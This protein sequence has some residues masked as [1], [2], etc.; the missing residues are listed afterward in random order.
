[1][2]CCACRE[3]ALRT[4]D[5]LFEQFHMEASCMIITRRVSSWGGLE[6]LYD[7][8]RCLHLTFALQYS[9]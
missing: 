2:A 6:V 1:M 8:T 4:H 9:V 5:I 3:T 7:I